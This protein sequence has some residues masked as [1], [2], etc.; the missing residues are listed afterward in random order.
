LNALRSPPS[1][2]PRR[3]SRA[4]RGDSHAENSLSDPINFEIGKRTAAYLEVPA[5]QSQ[6]ISRNGWP[7]QFSCR[8]AIPSTYWQLPSRPRTRSVVRL[9]DPETRSAFSA[10]KLL[11]GPLTPSRGRM[12]MGA[13]KRSSCPHWDLQVRTRRRRGA[14]PHK[15]ADNR[16]VAARRRNQFLRGLAEGRNCVPTFSRRI[17]SEFAPARLRISSSLAARK[18]RRPGPFAKMSTVGRAAGEPFGRFAAHSRS[19]SSAG[20]IARPI[21]STS[22][23][24]WAAPVDS[25]TRS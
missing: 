16:G 22:I 10:K 19:S 7:P 21:W 17:T 14:S 1:Y 5:R 4:A 20:H 9:P 18:Q 15:S 6:A 13:S 11:F 12:R 24:P 3:S 25:T 8:R 23:G 2:C